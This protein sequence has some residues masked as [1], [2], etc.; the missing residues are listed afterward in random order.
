MQDSMYICLPAN[1][2]PNRLPIPWHSNI[3][4]YAVVNRSSGMSST[5]MAGV[6]E[7]LEAKNRP[8]AAPMTI[9]DQKLLINKG[10]MAQQMPQPTRQIAY[11]LVTFIHG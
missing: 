11:T 6:N 5:K 7:K 4:P 10:M 2:G 8:N 1:G 3:R 9:R